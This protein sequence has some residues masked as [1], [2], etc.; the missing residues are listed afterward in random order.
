MSTNIFKAVLAVRKAVKKI[1]FDAEN[2]HGKYKYASS[3]AIVA[4]LRDAM[5][6]QGLILF[7]NEKS[8]SRLEEGGVQITFTFRLYTENAEMDCGER[9]VIMKWQ[10]PQT[11]QGAQSYAT[12]AFLKSFFLLTTGEPDQE[13]LVP[14][15]EDKKKP[16]AAQEL[17][18]K[19][20]HAKCMQIL[21][22]LMAR[23]TPKDD[24][25]KVIVGNDFSQKWGSD[26]ATLQASDQ[27][28]VRDAYKRFLKGEPVYQ[29]GDKA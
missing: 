4:G 29:I 1:A 24:A 18:G 6:E 5:D 8:F 22:D 13:S 17:T 15:P 26:I 19:A 7:V 14:A 2:P 28:V 23:E 11:F 16:K 20:S 9:T 27:K 25:D 12:K 21:E 3:D 10:G